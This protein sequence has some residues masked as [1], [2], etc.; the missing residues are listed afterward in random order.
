MGYEFD[1]GGQVTVPLAS[2]DDARDAVLAV[3]KRS[4][5]SYG[6]SLDEL[7]LG[8]LLNTIGLE[9]DDPEVDD[10]GTPGRGDD[11]VVYEIYGS[12]GLCD[13]KD[14]LYELSRFG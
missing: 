10:A 7:S 6:F 9:N 2:V 5:V 1:Y 13:Q 8:E 14:V 12:G 4:G 11:I 3:I